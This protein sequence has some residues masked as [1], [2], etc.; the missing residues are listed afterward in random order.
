M[1]LQKVGGDR[2]VEPKD[3]VN[4]SRLYRSALRECVIGLKAVLEGI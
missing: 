1:G 2:G 3:V 4:F